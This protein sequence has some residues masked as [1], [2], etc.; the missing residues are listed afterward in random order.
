MVKTDKLTDLASL[1][2]MILCHY[3]KRY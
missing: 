1:Q 3:Q 2:Q